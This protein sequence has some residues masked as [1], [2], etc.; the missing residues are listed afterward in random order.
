[1]KKVLITIVGILFLSPLFA[2]Q[3]HKSPEDKAVKFM[4]IVSERVELSAEQQTALTEIMTN[5]FAELK[6]LHEEYGREDFEAMKTEIDGL[7]DELQSEAGDV[8]DE[9]QMEAMKVVMKEMKEKRERMRSM[10][11][12]SP[13]ERHDLMIEKL[14]EE[15]NLSDAQEEEIRAI[16]DSKT[17]SMN[18]LKEQSEKNKEAVKTLKEQVES[19]IT[20]VLDA[21]QATKF[22]EIKAKQ[23]NE[24]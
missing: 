12:M 7:R 17:E 8:L 20:E 4:D 24:R 5:H 3:G 10:K 6:A 2:G 14:D 22:E 9:S 16:L 19:E 11:D 13:E 18:N 21:E 23:H 15:L 1:M